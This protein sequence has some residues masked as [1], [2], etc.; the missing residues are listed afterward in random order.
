MKQNRRNWAA[1]A[2]ELGNAVPTQPFYFLKPPSSFLAEGK[3]PIEIPRTAK[4]I[5][6]E[7]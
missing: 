4:E 2:K 5:H 1:H 3:A 7:G 6:H